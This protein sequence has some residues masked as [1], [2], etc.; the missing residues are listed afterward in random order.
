MAPSFHL[1]QSDLSS[2]AFSSIHLRP[3]LHKV[4]HQTN[5]TESGQD[6]NLQKAFEK[7]KQIIAISLRAN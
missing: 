3:I 7:N 5:F 2:M 4:S 1:N 6:I